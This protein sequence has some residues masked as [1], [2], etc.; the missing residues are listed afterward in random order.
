[1]IPVPTLSQLSDFSGRPAASYTGYA[2]SALLQAAI[3]F[4]TVTEVGYN[5]EQDFF[6]LTADDQLLATQGILAYADWIYLRQPYQQLIAAPVM[7]E[8]IGGY[9]VDE[10][11]E[12]LTADGWK[13]FRSLCQ[14]QEVLTL[15]PLTWQS[16]WQP[17]LEVC[18]FPSRQREMFRVEST[19]FSVLATLDH[20][21]LTR[22]RD[23][24]RVRW[25]TSG[26]LNSK[27][28]IPLAAPCADVPAEAKFSD[29]L[30]EA[31]AWF[32][33]EGSW[34]WRGRCRSV[35]IHQSHEAN[36]EK[37]DR[38]RAALTQLFG[39]DT[40]SIR[41]S[42]PCACW[43]ERVSTG[44]P[45]MRS[46]ALSALAS[47]VVT[48]HVF[49]DGPAHA[50]A[51]RTQ[52]LRSLTQAQLELFI[53]VSLLADGC[54]SP[55]SP[56]L[57]QRS[58]VAAEQFALAAIL[59]G[60]GVSVRRS[61][62]DMWV[63]TLLRRSEYCP[64]NAAYQ[65]GRTSLGTVVH[66]GPIWC[67]RT[68]NGTWLAR[69]RGSVYFTGNSYSKPPPVQVRNVQAQELGIGSTGVE[70]WDTA[71]QYLSKRTRSNGIF[72]GQM[73]C[74]ERTG[75]SGDRFEQIVVRVDCHTGNLMLLGP[76]DFNRVDIPGFGIGINAP[77]FPG[78][79][80]I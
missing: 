78:D 10:E 31:V 39:C 2:N 1:V 53:H 32:W 4:T 47:E 60:Q 56:Q 40:G 16:E 76:G 74:F 17:C 11:T 12:I 75:S 79:P 51:V 66:G 67:P 27:D 50:K 59:A 37:C 63:V 43:T 22:S 65:P 44:K 54:Y 18:V 58:K 68:S 8:T 80:G 19:Q 55:N 71:I 29:A 6:A 14:G 5:A 38:I 73:E 69:R 34:N 36:P 62:A 42:E 52:F 15:N 77:A 20:R 64:R 9:C 25:T 72:F 33:T 21:W 49:T 3:V 28:R 61:Q 24:G 30:V 45:G 26:R 23:S 7:S 41:R 70:L 46:F 13:D 35:T 48:Q 57:A